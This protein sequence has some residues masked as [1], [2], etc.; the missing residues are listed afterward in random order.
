MYA[1]LVP[2][3][4][5]TGSVYLIFLDLLTAIFSKCA[6]YESSHYAVS[7]SPL[8]FSLLAS[9]IFLYTLFSNALS[10]ISALFCRTSII[11]SQQSLSKP[12]QSL[13]AL[14]I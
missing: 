6:M 4:F 2:P 8:S 3:L 7:T 5:L 10:L 9:N 12:R 11:A 1:L 14:G 13:K